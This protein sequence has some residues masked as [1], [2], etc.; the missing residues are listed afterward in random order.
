MKLSYLLLYF[1]IKIIAGLLFLA[2]LSFSVLGLYEFI[3]SFSFSM[4]DE[5]G[6]VSTAV[7]LLKTIDMFLI[8]IVCFIFS[9]GL[10]ILF[11]NKQTIGSALNMPEWLKVKSFM[12]LKVI[13]WEAILTTLVV[14]FLAYLAQ[15]RFN[16]EPLGAE[17]LVVPASILLISLSLYALKRGE[18]KS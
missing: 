1:F 17:D 10:L 4:D 11:D 5:H 6:A 13:L 3:H 2:G 18:H 12:Q 14:A 8:A 16:N 9:L 7:L 15:K